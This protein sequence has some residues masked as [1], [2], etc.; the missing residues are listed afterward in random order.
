MYEPCKRRSRM[1]RA[2]VGKRIELSPRD[3]ELLKLLGRYRYLRS[4]FLYAFLGGASE[5]RFKE[6]LGHLYHDGGYINRPSQQWEF[7]NC[8]Y[9]PAVYEL[10]R[11]GERILREYGSDSPS[12]FLSAG[13]CGKPSR[14]FTHTLMVSEILA[15]IELAVRAV[16]HL[17]FI[18]PQE[19]IARA[20]DQARKA[21][22]PLEMAVSGG[23]LIPDGLF[24]I[25]YGSK[26]YRFFALEADRNTMPST[27]S[28]LRQSSFLRKLVAYRTLAAEKLHKSHWGIPNL[29]V[30]TVTTSDAH[31]RTLMSG[32]EG[33]TVSSTIFLFKAMPALGNVLHAACPCSTLL[34]EPWERVGNDP[35]SLVR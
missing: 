6:R 17:R 8:R 18:S 21:G 33:L 24:G 35:I 1:S 9:M 14:Q 16:P 26:A 10:D 19:V 20:P 29:L 12:S 2:G 32:L 13:R 4:N 25:E 34:T 28:D 15:S 3:L 27:R 23:K 11:A 31:M 30:L 22:N 5:K 7:A